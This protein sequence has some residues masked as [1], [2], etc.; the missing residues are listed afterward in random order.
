MKTATSAT[1]STVLNLRIGTEPTLLRPF[2]GVLLL[3]SKSPAETI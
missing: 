2:S 3:L 1:S